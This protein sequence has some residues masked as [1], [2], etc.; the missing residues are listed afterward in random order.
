MAQMLQSILVGPVHT[1]HLES[2]VLHVLVAASPKDP[3]VQVFTQA[4]ACKKYG[5]VHV[6]QKVRDVQVK[7][8]VH[9]AHTLFVESFQVAF[10]FILINKL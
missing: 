4:F 7:Q 3:V 8:V 9:G 6:K 5:T 10:F 2:H 1:E